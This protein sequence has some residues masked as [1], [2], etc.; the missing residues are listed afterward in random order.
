M[1]K[2]L[3]SFLIIRDGIKYDYNFKETIESL[4]EFCD[5]VAVVDC[6]STD[7]T[8]A[9]LM[10][11][12]DPKLTVQFL[13]SGEWHEIHG[14]EKLSYFQ[15]MAAEMLTTDYQLLCQADEVVD[16]KSYEFI[17][18]AME[19]GKEGFLCSRI[20]LW[21]SAATYLVVPENRMPCSSQVIRL[22]KRGYKCYDDGE[23]VG[24]QA[25]TQFVN[26][27]VI[28]HYGFIRKREVMKDKIINMQT[29]VFA[30]KDYDPKLDQ[31][32]VFDP[33]LWFKDTDLAPVTRPHPRIMQPWILQRM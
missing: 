8:V 28:W 12:T 18:R 17:R 15:N 26:D 16:E 7:G 19:T 9:E 27:I 1:N 23:N 13:I 6:G 5:Q 24:C 10:S 22:T 11:M 30:M 20:N 33:E 4:L 32:E 3:G 31:C 14:K 25:S 21:G 2:T 29:Q